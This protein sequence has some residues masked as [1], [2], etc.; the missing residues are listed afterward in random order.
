[1]DHL[2]L[3]VE[4]NCPAPGV[5]PGLKAAKDAQAVGVQAEGAEVLD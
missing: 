2:K 1:M 3:S 5:M 4:L